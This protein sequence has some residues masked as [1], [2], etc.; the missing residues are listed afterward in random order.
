MSAI[1]SGTLFA[2][3]LP[4]TGKPAPPLQFAQ[5]LQAPDG[6]RTDWESL[7]GKV[8]VLEFWFSS[9]G[10]C[11]AEIPHM[12]QLA[13]ALDPAKFQFIAVN[14]REDQDV[15]KKFLDKKKMSGWVGVDPEG[16]VAASYGVKAFPTT[17]IVDAQGKIAGSTYPDFLQAADLQAVAEGKSVKFIHG[18]EAPPSSADSASGETEKPLFEITLRKS[19]NQSLEEMGMSGFPTG[20]EMHGWDAVSLVLNIYQLAHNRLILTSPMPEGRYDLR[21]ES[22]KADDAVTRPMLQTAITAG[23]HLR[24]TPKTV[25]KKAYIL[26]ATPAGKILLTPTV[27]NGGSMWMYM[28]GKV[29]VVNQSTDGLRAA[30]ENALDAP[31]VDETGIEGKFDAEVEFPMKDAV[32]AKTALLKTLGLDLIE[33]DRP[34]AML[35]VTPLDEPKKAVESKPQETPKK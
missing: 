3:T 14:N 15:V 19:K 23:L 32:A 27:S 28:N 20:M 8:V 22:A 21:I 16:Q 5:L 18:M 4:D 1:L 7:R 26:K 33:G 13:A 9:C 25:T 2:G 30:L 6:T 11:V 29:K 12:N 34:I 17:I 10:P 35:E 31:V 24:I